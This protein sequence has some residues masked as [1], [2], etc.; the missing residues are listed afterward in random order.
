[1]DTG[2][3]CILCNSR[4]LALLTRKTHADAL[5]CDLR[6]L[7]RDSYRPCPVCDRLCF[8]EDGFR[9]LKGARRFVRAEGVSV[10][11]H[12]TLAAMRRRA[13]FVQSDP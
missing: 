7:L 8:G 11:T 4:R 5:V 12:E 10:G 1:M 3:L 13:G 2:G 9:V 6:H